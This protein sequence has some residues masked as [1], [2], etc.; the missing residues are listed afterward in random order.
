MGEVKNNNQ[1]A[2]G[3]SKVGGGWQESIDNHTSMTAGNDKQCNP[4][5]DFEGSNK[6]GKG[7][8]GKGKGGQ[9]HCIGNEGS[10]Q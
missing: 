2:T 7:N 10:M 6:E 1:L 8:K 3:V 4:A 5:T 9:G